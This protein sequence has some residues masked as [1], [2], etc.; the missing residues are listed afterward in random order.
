[1]A[2]KDL[3]NRSDIYSLGAVLYEMLTGEPPHTG[4]SAQAIV[5]K[6][7]SED[8]QPVTELRKSVP[9]HVAAATGKALEKLAADRFYS[10]AEFAEALNDPHFTTTSAVIASEAEPAPSP[11]GTRAMAGW[12]VAATLALI[13][14]WTIL[15]PAPTVTPPVPVRFTLDLIDQDNL[16][17]GDIVVSPDG[18]FFALPAFAGIY[19]RPAGDAS[20]RLLPNTERA[21]HPA[22][23]PDS[24]WL[25]FV[26]EGVLVKIAVDGSAEQT[27]L[28]SNTLIASRPN[29]GYPATIVFQSQGRLYRI[30]DNGGEPELLGGGL[31]GFF[32]SLL[33]DGS[34]VLYHTSAGIMLFEF[35]SDSGQLVVPQGTNAMY[36]ETGHVAYG[37]LGG[38]LFVVPFDLQ[39]RTVTGS[40]VS[41]LDD[42]AILFQN[43]FYSISQTGTLLYSTNPLAAGQVRQLL[44]LDLRDRGIDTIPL[45]PRTFNWPRFSPDG[46]WLSFNTGAGRIEQRTVYTYDIATG[47]TNQITSG[48][49]AHA[50][51]WSPDGSRLVFSSERDGT[52]GEDLFITP[53]DGRSP[54]ISLGSLPGDDHAMAWLSD[55]LIAVASAGM[56]DLMLVDPSEPERPATPYLNAEWLESGLSVS[57]EGDRAAYHSDETGRVEVYVRTFP[58]PGGARRIS[59]NGGTA[60]H[61]SPDGRTVYYWAL[62]QDT[63]FAVPMQP[64]APSFG[65][66][67]VVAV[68]PRVIGQWDVDRISGRAVVMQATEEDAQTSTELVVVVNWFEELKAKVGN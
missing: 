43:A 16:R 65:S 18:S 36:I 1:T 24:R 21:I 45:T 19:V 34:G 48:G 4:A 9:P 40:S 5:M 12:A 55:D 23:S 54:E 2:E 27:L 47:T 62:S 22:F 41:V 7:V 42:I 29:W 68:I 50:A 31:N 58:Q 15:G 57:P 32:P 38:G 51:A 25:V 46:R 8:V 49:G 52:V 28:R 33:P 10:A 13:L 56:T 67:Q 66:P 64:D 35:G 26:R 14:G 11:S 3:T 20:Y 60:P 44:L 30:S 37:R 63:I 39:T 53:V 6:I 59:A 61:W 17:L